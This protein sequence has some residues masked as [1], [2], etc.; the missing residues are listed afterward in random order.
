MKYFRS[1][2]VTSLLAALLLPFTLAS[3][4]QMNISVEQA[5]VA[6][7]TKYLEEMPTDAGN[8]KEPLYDAYTVWFFNCLADLD[9]EDTD[10][11]DTPG[12]ASLKVKVKGVKFKLS[13]PMTIYVSKTAD[14]LVLEHEQGHV[15]LSSRVYKTAPEAARKAARAIVGKSFYGMGKDLK[16]AREM[17][18]AQGRRE[19]SYS[20][21]K[22]VLEMADE[23]SEAYD[24][25]AR[26]NWYEKNIT[27]R[28]CIEKAYK[29]VMGRKEVTIKEK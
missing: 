11:D 16:E 22:D 7:T 21:Q 5:P 3:C 23:L 28:D 26:T 19:L 13:C 15:E 12:A 25:L 29:E 10:V 24:H 8:R 1:V 20:F 4:G 27:T 9:T 14:K 6:V 2:P 17:G 18:I